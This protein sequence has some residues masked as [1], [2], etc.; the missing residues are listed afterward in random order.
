MSGSKLIFKLKYRR[1]NEG[2]LHIQ[3]GKLQKC[4]RN[5]ISGQCSGA[6]NVLSGR[7]TASGEPKI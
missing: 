7:N 4:K 2:Y 6:T 1:V 3:K 5:K